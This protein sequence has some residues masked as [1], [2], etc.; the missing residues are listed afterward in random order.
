V[1]ILLFPIVGGLA[2]LLAGRPKRVP[3]GPATGAGDGWG[4]GHG[5]P[6]RPLAPD[7]DPA[8]LEGL[9]RADRDHEDV[10]RRWEEDLRRR[11]RAARGEEDEEPGAA[12]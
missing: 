8:F 10:L 1:L 6:S 7:D 4:P 11:E 12:R 3:A 9:R 2:W 5:A